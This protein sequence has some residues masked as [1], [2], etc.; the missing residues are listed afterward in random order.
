MLCANQEMIRSVLR[1]SHRRTR[2]A[3]RLAAVEPHR[4][5]QPQLRPRAVQRRDALHRRGPADAVRH[6]GDACA[7]CGRSR[8]RAHFTVPR[9][10]EA[11]MPYLRRRRGAARAFLQPAEAVVLRGCRPQPAVLRRAQRDGRAVVRRGHPV[12]DRVW[13]HRDR[14]VRA[15]HRPR[16]RVVGRARPA[17]ARAWSSS[18]RR[19]ARRSRR[20]CAGRTSRRVTFATTR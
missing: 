2:R 15:Q 13:R 7:T 4:R 14:A 5:R 8:R 11:L 1:V 18:W 12:D 20:A 9:F 17:R 19:S 3:L 10:Y 16:G 6:R